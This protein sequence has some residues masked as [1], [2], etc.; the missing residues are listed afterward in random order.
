MTFVIDNHVIINE[1]T[2]RGETC[3]L[4]HAHTHMQFTA[5][6]CQTMHW[7]N[8]E[9]SAIDNV[10][11][12]ETLLLKATQMYVSTKPHAV[13]EKYIH[14]DPHTYFACNCQTLPCWKNDSSTIEQC[15]IVLEETL[16][17]TVTC[18]TIDNNVN[19][20]KTSSAEEHVVHWHTQYNG[21]QLPNIALHIACQTLHC[22]TLHNVALFMQP[23]LSRLWCLYMY[24]TCIP[25]SLIMST[26]IHSFSHDL[27]SSVHAQ[28]FVVHCDMF[29]N[30]Q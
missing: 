2:F 26:N 24:H 27:Y 1:I 6:N 15:H 10:T 19:A 17:F 25:L 18:F 11:N 21:T 14:W 3:I 4:W 16:L 30:R 13:D 9:W 29:H 20:N 23:S 8:N 12:L 7:L 28:V 22:Q 5:C